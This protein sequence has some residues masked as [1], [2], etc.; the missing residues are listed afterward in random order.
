MALVHGT[1]TWP[2]EGSDKGWGVVDLA[3]GNLWVPAAVDLNTGATN[4]WTFLTTLAIPSA[5]GA[6]LLGRGAGSARAA[7]DALMPPGAVQR[8]TPADLDAEGQYTPVQIKDGRIY[9]R[10]MEE[11]WDGSTWQMARNLAGVGTT[12]SAPLAVA[13]PGHTFLHT[14]ANPSPTGTDITDAGGSALTA[15]AFAL[16]STNQYWRIPRRG[17]RDISIN[18]AVSPALDAGGSF[19]LYA[20]GRSAANDVQVWQAAYSS[21]LIAQW[22]VARGLGGIGGAAA[23]TA[24]I[25][26]GV[27]YDVPALDWAVEYLTLRWASGAAPTAGNLELTVTRNR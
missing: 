4:A 23:G 20:G 11:L 21:G 8:A 13:A 1:P 25:A 2:V 22:Q 5:T 6:N 24:T 14:A 9:T 19:V 3:T 17:W 18:V 27:I 26:N 7:G 10:A 15:P 16:R 12:L